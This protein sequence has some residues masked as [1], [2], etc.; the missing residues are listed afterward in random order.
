LVRLATY[1]RDQG[2]LVNL[3][4]CMETDTKDFVKKRR[5][6]VGGRPRDYVRGDVTKA[7]WHF[8]LGWDEVVKRLKP[9]ITE[10]VQQPRIS[11][12]PDSPLTHSGRAS[13]VVLNGSLD[14]SILDNR[15]TGVH[16]LLP[17]CN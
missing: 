9:R 17:T 7:I 4:D 8:G 1:L 13:R 5:R 10:P 6:K 2:Y 15:E 12:G 11:G 3:V 14:N 16:L